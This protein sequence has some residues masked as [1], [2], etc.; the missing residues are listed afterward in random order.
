M[1]GD[2]PNSYSLGGQ[3]KS[4]EFILKWSQVGYAPGYQEEA[5]ENLFEE[6]AFH[7]GLK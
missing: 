1:Q 3:R 6:A 2:N 7:L 4:R 5:K